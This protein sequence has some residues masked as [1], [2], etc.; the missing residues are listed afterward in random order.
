MPKVSIIGTDE[1]MIRFDYN[2]PGFRAKGIYMMVWQYVFERKFLEDIRF[3]DIQPHEDIIFMK[4]VF[5][6]KGNDKVLYLQIPF[7]L[8]NY[9]R[10][11]SNMTQYLEKGKIDP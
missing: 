3:T 2:A 8:Y 6:K 5:K 1:P 11:G 9:K 10:P 7:Y 4:E